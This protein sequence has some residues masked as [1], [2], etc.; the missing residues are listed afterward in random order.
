MQTIEMS[1]FKKQIHCKLTF[2]DQIRRFIFNGTEFS[3]L[4]GHISILLSLPVDG[5]VLKYIDNESDLITITNNEDLQ[6]AL[7]LSDKLLRLVVETPSVPKCSDAPL[8]SP[9]ST[10]SDL[11]PSAHPGFGPDRG[12]ERG[13]G[14]GWGHGRGGWGGRHGFHHPHHAHPHGHHWG[15]HGMSE[16]YQ[17]AGG[18]P[19]ERN[20]SW[21]C[22]KAKSRI[23][24]KL[25]FLK[26]TLD[27]LPA[28]ENFRRQHMLMKIH[29]LEGR[30]L[31][32]D[33]M[34]EKKFNKKKNKEEKKKWDKKLTPEALQQVQTLKAQ[35][36]SLKPVLYQLKITKKAKKSELE[37]Y[38]QSGQ[39]DKETIWNEILRLKE[40]INETE[41]Q[42]SALKDQIQA[43]R[44]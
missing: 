37:L 3:E 23:Q 27:Q 12:F 30:L 10:S 17:G 19:G 26:T 32:W 9:Q 13:Y 11:P 35:I 39:G 4:R 2:N 24:N 14:R 25:D 7:E 43:I 22:E 36:A 28:E 1:D 6:L 18:V 29:R 40:S 16:D 41:K 5:F 44:G 20:Q 15:R 34:Q 33:A 31:R 38:L 21:K 42:I 8:S